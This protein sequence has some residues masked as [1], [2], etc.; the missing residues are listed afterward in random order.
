MTWLIFDDMFHITSL[1]TARIIQKES[2]SIIQSI[3]NM[4][5]LYICNHNIDEVS[6]N[7]LAEVQLRYINTSSGAMYRV[8]KFWQKVGVAKL[9]FH[10]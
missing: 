7:E 1:I 4:V 2:P 9:Y 8:I 5:S 6:K 10:D 3:A